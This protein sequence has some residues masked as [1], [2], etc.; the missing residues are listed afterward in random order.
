ME[1]PRRGTQLICPHFFFGG[2]RPV[3][4]ALSVKPALCLCP[5]GLPDYQGQPLPLLA[6]KGSS[7]QAVNLPFLSTSFKKAKES[8]DKDTGGGK[9]HNLHCSKPPL[10]MVDLASFHPEPNILFLGKTTN[11]PSHHASLPG[12]TNP[13]R[14]SPVL[15]RIRRARNHLDSTGHP[16]LQLMS[17]GSMLSSLNFPMVFGTANHKTLHCHMKRS[18]KS[19]RLGWH[20]SNSLWRKE[21]RSTGEKSQF[22]C[23][24]PCLWRISPW[25]WPASGQMRASGAS[26]YIQSPICL[27]VCWGFL[28]VCFVG[29]F[30]NTCYIT[31]TTLV[32]TESGRMWPQPLLSALTSLQQCCS[33]LLI[34]HCPSCSIRITLNSYS[35]VVS[36]NALHSQARYISTREQLC[37]LS[38]NHLL[39]TRVKSVSAKDWDFLRNS[40][41]PGNEIPW[42]TRAAT[43]L[44]RF[45][46]KCKTHIS[47]H[48]QHSKPYSD[49]AVH[50][51][52]SGGEGN[53]RHVADGNRHLE[54]PEAPTWGSSDQM[55]PPV[56]LFTSIFLG[57]YHTISR[58]NIP[59]F[60]QRFCSRKGGW[61]WRL[62]LFHKVF[63][64]SLVRARRLLRKWMKI[65]LMTNICCTAGLYT[66][67]HST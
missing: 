40:V 58:T 6:E 41:R 56:I 8:P 14:W 11:K 65:D 45:W 31:I 18:Q 17:K 67:I 64:L 46:F 54:L 35:P 15:S 37:L 10:S 49:T 25:F 22:L 42:D 43:N 47:C 48:M 44:I 51:V 34:S 1:A 52:L 28:F 5:M 2:R 61:H 39:L 29:F 33:P 66:H 55:L 21:F 13:D 62:A 50:A 63:A 27:F 9:Q 26:N 23:Q 53:E 20:G 59:S 36:S 32:Q 12:T 4:C 38:T 24:I 3:W 60:A 57:C 30:Y 7:P 16:F 19:R